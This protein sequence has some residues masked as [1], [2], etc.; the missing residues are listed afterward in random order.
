MRARGDE[1]VSDC[2]KRII[3][4]YIVNLLVISL[5]VFGCLLSTSICIDIM[6]RGNVTRMS[7]GRYTCTPSVHY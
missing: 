5:V 4:I 1:K 2:R 7:H 3:Y 6:C